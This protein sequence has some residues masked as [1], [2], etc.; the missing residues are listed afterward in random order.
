M[1]AF[2]TDRKVGEGLFGQFCAAVDAEILILRGCFAAFFADFEILCRFVCHVYH[3]SL[4]SCECTGKGVLPLCLRVI[5]RSPRSLID[6]VRR[7]ID[8][9]GNRLVGDFLCS[10]SNRIPYRL[11]GNT[12]DCL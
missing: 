9:W 2:R 5:L 6:T 7:L 10:G 8:L 1:T 11:C 4:Q 12:A 3:S